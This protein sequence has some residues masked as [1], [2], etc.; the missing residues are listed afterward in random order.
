MRRGKTK[1]VSV[2]IADDQ[3][4]VRD[5]LMS[6]LSS[7]DEILVIGVAQDGAGA[8]ALAE[9]YDADVVLMDLRMPGT[10]GVQATRTL[11]ISRPDTAVVVLTTM[12]DDEWLPAAL[13]AG[14]TSFL[15]KGASSQDIR[16]AV[17]AA[18]DRSR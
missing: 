16:R 2:V 10:N 6:I 14:A 9:Q 11:G 7:V 18:G 17:L 4:D 12:E 8:V 3:P 1:L 15:T 5:G 13:A